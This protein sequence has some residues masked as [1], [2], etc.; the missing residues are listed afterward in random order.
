MRIFV[1]KEKTEN[2]LFFKRFYLF[3]ERGRE[4]EREG[5]KHQLAASHMPPTRDLTYNPSM[6]HDQESN[7]QPFGLRD[8]AQP[9]ESYQSGHENN[10]G[11]MVS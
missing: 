9:T 2:N 10:L 7:Q 3:L 6:C 8:D 11:V 5:E 4:G 1:I